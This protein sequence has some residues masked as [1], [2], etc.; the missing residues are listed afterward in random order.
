MS[1]AGRFKNYAKTYKDIG[2]GKTSV[3][4]AWKEAQKDKGG[5]VRGGY[6][7]GGTKRKKGKVEVK[8]AMDSKGGDKSYS[9]YFSKG[10]SSK[11]GS[12][13]Y[14]SKGGSSYSSK[15]QSKLLKKQ[16]KAAEKR[17]KAMRKAYD[18]LYGTLHKNLLAQ[19]DSAGNSRKTALAGLESDYQNAADR[20][21]RAKEETGKFY[22]DKET[23]LRGDYKKQKEERARIFQARNITNSSYYIDA[24]TEADTEFNKVL[25]RLNEDEARTVAEQDT[26]L[27]ELGQTRMQKRAEI[28]NA[29]ADMMR[30]IENNLAKTDFEKANA[31]QN[32]EDE[33]NSK[34]SVI[35]QDL[36]TIK[37]QQQEFRDR[38]TNY[39]V[40]RDY[41]NGDYGYDINNK[42]LQK[43]GASMQ[44]QIKA[45]MM[46]GKS[47]KKKDDDENRF[48]SQGRQQS[49]TQK[50]QV[51]MNVWQQLLAKNKLK[52]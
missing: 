43:K 16:K 20:S 45:A 7:P 34:M 48:I 42:A 35:N 15:G 19:R 11:S 25:G 47:G 32:L 51:A 30:Q 13:K 2:L 27:K 44:D 40:S 12:R 21:G 14:R 24:I 22:D 10:G 6:H 9:K 41:Q 39:A 8:G 1:I 46:S 31:M 3:K 50:N 38:V 18:G 49:T 29:F 17:R 36:L 33:Y 23:D 28:E 26:Q 37:A 4:K 5:F 52:K